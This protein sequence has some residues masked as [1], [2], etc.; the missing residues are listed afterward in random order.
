VP[1]T[2][3]RRYARALFELASE[4]HQL[5]A[6]QQRLDEVRRIFAVPELRSVIENPAVSP[7]Q[8]LGLI[9]S[10]PV[11]DLGTEGRNLAK[12]LVESAHSDSID[13]IEEEFAR[14]AD[15][16]RGRVQVTVTT[17]VDLQEQERD[18]LAQRLGAELGREVRLQYRTDPTIL[19]GLV[20]LIG[21]RLVDASLRSRLQ[22]L[23]RQLAGV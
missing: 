17:A 21:D 22:Q 11:D 23:R 19:G 4:E 16:E 12:L 7:D 14:L 15:E 2:T 5:D 20:V 13:D 3:A 18:R 1:S 6:W 10:L 8:R 9:D